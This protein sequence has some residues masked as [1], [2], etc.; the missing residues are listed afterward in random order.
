PTGCGKTEIARRLAKLARAPFVKVEAS[1]FTE[2]GY[3]GRD[4]ESMI[5]DL[6]DVAVQ[7]VQKEAVEEVSARAE[8]LAEDRLVELLAAQEAPPEPTPPSQAKSQTFGP[9]VL[10]PKAVQAANAMMGKGTP[11]TFDDELLADV[12]TRLRKGEFDEALVEVDVPDGGSPFMTVFGQGG[13]EEMNLRDMM[14]QLPGFGGRTKRRKLTVPEARKVLKDQEAQN[15]IDMDGVQRRAVERTEQSGI[16]F[17]DEIDKV[18]GRNANGPDV[19]R[20][21]VQRDL[22]PVVEGSTVNTK[23]GPVKTDH[24]LFIAAGAFHVSAVG[25]LIPELQGRFPIRVELESLKKEDFVRILSEP[26]NALTRQYTALMETEGVELSFDAS[27]IEAIASY[28][29]LANHRAENI[30]ARRLHTVM[31]ALLE[32]LSFTAPSKKGSA[33]VVDGEYVKKTLEPV[34]ENDA[35]ARYVL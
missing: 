25:D 33:V 34:M 13:M 4:V 1:K 17:L 31:E 20:E 5:R 3:V 27:G 15:L 32:E 9:F 28:A 2:V 12:R 7:L 8:G 24:I 21:G 23:F 19:S 30:G 6:V 29:A 11:R 14:Q 18:A 26:K 35:L 16:V 10:D 22:L